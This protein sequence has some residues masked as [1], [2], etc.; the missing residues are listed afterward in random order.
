M[1]ISPSF[2]EFSFQNVAEIIQN[3]LENPF[4]C[5]DAKSEI[6]RFSWL[7]TLAMIGWQQIKNW[8]PSKV[9][10]LVVIIQI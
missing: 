9:V 6:I 5:G 4:E 2:I 8:K 1:R 10:I 3:R 7:S